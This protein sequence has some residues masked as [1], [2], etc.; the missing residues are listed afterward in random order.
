MWHHRKYSQVKFMRAPCPE[1]ASTHM[2]PLPILASEQFVFAM[3]EP[4]RAAKASKSMM[5]RAS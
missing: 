4:K 1:W 2:A 3:M 5:L